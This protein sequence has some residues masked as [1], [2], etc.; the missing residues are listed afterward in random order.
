MFWQRK[1]NNNTIYVFI[2]IIFL[3]FIIQPIFGNLFW[4]LDKL[5]FDSNLFTVTQL[6]ANVG[7]GC[8]IV[9]YLINM[10]LNGVTLG[11]VDVSAIAG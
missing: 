7:V 5:R 10:V 2:I 11:K 6:A 8:K 3:Y 1:L 9:P 4:E